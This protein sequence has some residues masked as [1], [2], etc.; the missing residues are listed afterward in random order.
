MRV[1]Q[2]FALGARDGQPEV[3]VHCGGDQPSNDALRLLPIE[4][5]DQAPADEDGR[6]VGITAEDERVGRPVV[7][8]QE[9]R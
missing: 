1:R 5:I 7:V 2:P 8:E 3:A 9:A 6:V 4:R